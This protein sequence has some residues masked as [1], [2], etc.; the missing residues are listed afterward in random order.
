MIHFIL[1]KAKRIWVPPSGRKKGYWRQDPRGIS[2][3]VSEPA[4]PITEFVYHVTRTDA[5]P[6]IQEKGILPLQTSNWVQAASKERYGGGEIFVF[7]HPTD[8]MKWAAKMDWEFNKDMGS[9][10]ISVVQLKRTDDPKTG[11]WMVDEADPLSQAGGKGRWLK[12][13]GRVAPEDVVRAVPLTLELTRRMT[14]QDP[15]FSDVF[16]S[17]VHFILEKAKS[18]GSIYVD[19]DKTLAYHETEWGASKLGHPIPK[20]VSRVKKW[21]KEGKNVKVFT[22]RATEKGQKEKIQNWLEKNGLPKLEVTNIKKPD[23]I[24]LWD[25]RARQ[26]EPNTGEEV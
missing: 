2:E 17:M 25:D 4:S 14:A 11:R 5:I 19:F 8:A 3:E 23:L 16:K 18:E 15:D 9:G 20:M 24:E 1:E 21:L 26:V 6:K 13:R 22:A 12:K 7:E 10:K